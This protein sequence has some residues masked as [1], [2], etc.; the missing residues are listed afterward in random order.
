MDDHRQHDADE[1]EDR[2]ME[3]RVP[4]HLGY[5]TVHHRLAEDVG[6]SLAEHLRGVESVA[7]NRVHDQEP[8]RDGGG[9]D[10]PREDS[11]SNEIVLTFSH[12][13]SHWRQPAIRRKIRN[14]PVY[15]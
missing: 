2:V 1:G 3:Y 14:A 8:D 7:G 12:S 6:Q 5:R 11:F 10:E 4:D 13:H 15:S 9:A